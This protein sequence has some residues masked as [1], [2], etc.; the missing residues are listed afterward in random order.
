MSTHV[1]D[2][3]PWRNPDMPTM[4]RVRNCQCCPL[5]DLNL[6]GTEVNEHGRCLLCQLEWESLIELVGPRAVVAAWNARSGERTKDRKRRIAA[7]H[8]RKV[9]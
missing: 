4:R 2:F 8:A 1:D 6:P 5:N 3:A 7:Y 9:A